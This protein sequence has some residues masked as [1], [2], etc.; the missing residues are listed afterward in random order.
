M[1]RD[2]ACAGSLGIVTTG[3]RYHSQ[4]IITDVIN[5]FV[6][7]ATLHLTP[8]RPFELPFR[9]VEWTMRLQQS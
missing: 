5:V 9:V 4:M 6:G 1:L 3:V 8:K 7:S 2:V